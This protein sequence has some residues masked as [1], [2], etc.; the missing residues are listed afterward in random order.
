MF[1]LSGIIT[2][3]VSYVKYMKSVTYELVDW[4]SSTVAKKTKARTE[5]RSLS[6]GMRQILSHPIPPCLLSHRGWETEQ[7]VLIPSWIV[8]RE[9]ICHLL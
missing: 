6:M 3:T 8:D 1:P 7:H 9:T 2:G 5:W 4:F